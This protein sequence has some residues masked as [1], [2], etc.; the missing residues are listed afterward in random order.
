MRYVC[1]DE[2]SS[3]LDVSRSR[4]ATSPHTIEAAGGAGLHG[5]AR[6]C[7]VWT[8]AASLSMV[9]LSAIVMAEMVRGDGKKD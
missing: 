4:T 3:S 9:L 2:E 1:T 5:V 6:E 7:V 8:D